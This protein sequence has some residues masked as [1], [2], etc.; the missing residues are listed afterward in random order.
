MNVYSG[1][2]SIPFIY[3]PNFTPVSYCFANY[4]FV[5]N[6]NIRKCE[7]FSFIII[8]QDH[9]YFSRLLCLFWSLGFSCK[10]FESMFC[11]F[12]CQQKSHLRFWWDSLLCLGYSLYAKSKGWMQKRKL[13]EEYSPQTLTWN[14]LSTIQS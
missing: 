9:Y 14:A 4:I 10:F 5:V 2:K 1:L 3:I 12:K 6:V 11:L 7:S 13:I 8:F